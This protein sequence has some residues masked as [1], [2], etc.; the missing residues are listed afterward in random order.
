MHPPRTKTARLISPK[1]LRQIVGWLG[2][3]LPLAMVTGNH[4]FSN[5][6]ELQNSISHY[7]Y[8]ITGSWLTGNL[9]AVA[10][11]LVAYKGY[12]LHDNIAA[13]I[14]GFCAVLIALFPTNAVQHVPAEIEKNSCLLFTLPE[15]AL[16]NSIHYASSGLFFVTLAYISIALFRKGEVE[17][18]ANKIIRNRIFLTCGIVILLALLLIVLYGIFEDRLPRL[19]HLKPVFWLEWL[20]LLAFGISWLV[21][22]EIVLQDRTSVKED[23]KGTLNPGGSNVHH[24]F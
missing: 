6:N 15:H 3:L 24:P 16:R 19:D 22:G 20:A 17:K 9:C 7:Y 14:A 1:T 11:F 4:L 12:S 18:S 8:T 2:I 13:T 23:Q 10:M 5:C 21:K